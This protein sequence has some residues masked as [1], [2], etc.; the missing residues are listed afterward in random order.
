AC[1]TTGESPT[2]SPAEWQ[3]VVETCV[4]EARGLPVLAG[5]GTNS[6]A[7]TVERTRLAARL[8]ASGALVVA[9]YYNRPTQAGLLGH[10]EQVAAAAGGFPLVLYNIPGRTG[11]NMTPATVLTLSRI[12]G[13]RGIKEASG[14]LDQAS[15]IAA[16]ADPEAFAV[17]AG[18]DAMTL[19]VLAVG[20]RGVVS[21]TGNVAPRLMGD[22][23]RR[24]EA[25][26]T[27]GALAAHRR[28]L[29][30]IRLL[31][32]ETNPAPVKAALALMGLCTDEVRSPLAALSHQHREP[33]AHVLRDLE[34]LS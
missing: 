30:L 21:T 13:I 34:L 23:T 1:G 17:L 14:S 12:P 27:A 8:G 28:L 15:E 19:P 3:A 25:G 11:V 20:G 18:D 6:T 29:P 26:D 5:T 22:V 2:L 31:F 24:W 9:P 16:G 4:S 10:F 33:L 7:S 32:V